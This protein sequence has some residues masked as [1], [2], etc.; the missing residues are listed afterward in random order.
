MQRIHER[1]NQVGGAAF[2]ELFEP[3]MHKSAMIGVF[4][5]ILEL[6]RHHSVNAEQSEGQNDIVITPGEFFKDD[7]DFGDVDDYSSKPDEG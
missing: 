4:L 3:G 2:S 7:Q 6:I 5:A 1:L